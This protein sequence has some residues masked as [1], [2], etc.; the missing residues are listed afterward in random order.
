MSQDTT[1][2]LVHALNEVAHLYRKRIGEASR[3]HRIVLEIDPI[4]PLDWL[5][6]QTMTGS[7]YWQDRD[8]A[9]RIAAVGEADNVTVTDAKDLPAALQRIGDMLRNSQAAFRYFGGVRF[10]PDRPQAA[11]DP[12]WDRFGVARFVL[13][14]FEVISES[15]KTHLA[16]NVLEQEA[17]SSEI[18]SIIASARQLR[19]DAP[20]P[21][22]DPPHLIGRSDKPDRAQWNDLINEMLAV[23]SRG[24][25]DKLVSARRTTLELGYAAEPWSLL[26]RL[27]DQN[28]NCFVFGFKTDNFAT[29]MGASPERLYRREKNH[30]YTEA[31]AGT[32]PVAGDSAANDAFASDLLES[33]KDRREH[34]LVVE[35]VSSALDRVCER[36][37]IV[38]SRG[39]LRLRTLQHLIT[40]IEGE[41]RSDVDDC[42][43][44]SALH[45]TPAVGGSP[46]DSAVRY[47]R[48]HEPFDRGWYSSP[49][50]WIGTESAEFAVAIRSA[51]VHDSQADIFAGAG[52]VP[53]SD[54][55]VEWMEVENKI[56][57]FLIL[58]YGGR[59]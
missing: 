39:L 38:E 30:V 24:E 45:P 42:Q 26:K 3:I 28:K 12:R 11:C 58:L 55:D 44:L 53:G 17:E 6:A 25:C 2:R 49:V 5:R 4:D 41:L 46:K 13:P 52:I 27:R 37:S 40:R 57:P 51:L 18:E 36:Y 35:G 15:G 7:F 9:Q 33:V 47:L 19:F 10:D 29:F 14:R 59:V 23:F 16:C 54:A 1:T 20:P 21:V 22:A 8:G 31:V 50:G 34:E 56:L 32:R 48:E 43:L